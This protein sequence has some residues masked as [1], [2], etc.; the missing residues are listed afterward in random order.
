MNRLKQDLAASSF[1]EV[2]GRDLK[3]WPPMA[4]LPRA[5]GGS[6]HWA[7]EEV[8]HP[9]FRWVPPWSGSA[10][11]GPPWAWL[12]DRAPV[13]L[14]GTAGNLPKREILVLSLHH[15]E[16]G[17]WN[18]GVCS[19][20]AMTLNAHCDPSPGLGWARVINRMSLSPQGTHRLSRETH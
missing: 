14:H 15:R 1:W 20:L 7:E 13:Q 12:V 11:T 4:A 19:H 9:A 6:D 17:R 10:E 3:R 2:G 5:N 16:W 18:E 8:S